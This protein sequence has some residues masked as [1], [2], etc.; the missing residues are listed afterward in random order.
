[1]FSEGF[2]RDFSLATANI[3][4]GEYTI[5]NRENLTPETAPYAAMSSGSIPVVFQPRHFDGNLYMDGGTIY[6]V[7]IPSAIQGCL[8][9]GYPQEKIIVDTLV[10]SD[11][12]QIPEF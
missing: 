11:S 4:T 10:C 8:D 7:N 9:K 5:Y 2:K 12:Q 1:M 3:E 6:N